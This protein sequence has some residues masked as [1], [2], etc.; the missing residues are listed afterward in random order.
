MA[1]TKYS[2]FYNDR[3][4]T[5]K[6]FYRNLRNLSTSVVR[7][8][9]GSSSPLD[10]IDITEFDNRK[11][12]DYRRRLLGSGGY[13]PVTMFLRNGNDLDKFKIQKSY[14]R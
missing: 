12:N 11:F 8:Y 1:Q 14:K 4:V 9:G 3:Q 7:S 2:Y 13:V 10:R 5:P 6:V